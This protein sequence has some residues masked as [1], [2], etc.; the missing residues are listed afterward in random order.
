MD[1]AQNISLYDGSLFSD[2]F[3]LLRK[4]Y[5]ITQKDL[6][7]LLRYKSR[8]NIAD[9]ESGRARPSFEV[10][11]R[12]H[13]FYGVSIDWLMGISDTPYS[14]ESISR[15]EKYAALNESM[16]LPNEIKNYVNYVYNGKEPKFYTLD[17]RFNL[18][19]FRNFFV[20]NVAHSNEWDNPTLSEKIKSFL[21]TLKIPSD[22]EFRK[23][24]SFAIQFDKNNKKIWENPALPVYDLNALL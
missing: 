10:L 5:K 20:G 16:N 18:L 9:L 11:L 2:R 7:M 21:L 1:I 24:M 14:E 15:A 8:S 3:I 4:L 22:K 13:H 12:I 19:F 17:N 6:A 23:K